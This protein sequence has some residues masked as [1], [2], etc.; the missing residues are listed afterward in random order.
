[1]RARPVRGRGL[2][3]LRLALVLSALLPVG[4]TGGGS[5]Q[6]A[7]YP[8][9]AIS[10]C[11]PR[12]RPEG[13]RMPA[14]CGR[15]PADRGWVCVDGLLWIESRDAQAYSEGKVFDGRGYVPFAK[16]L[17]PGVQAE[18]GFR[19]RTDHVA[20]QS[21]LAWGRAKE[22]A[23]EAQAHVVRLVGA[24]GDTLGLRLPADPLPV[25]VYATRAEFEG[26]LSGLVH[27][28]VGWGAFYDARTGVVHM[29]AEPAV[30]GALPW[31]ADLRHEMTHQILDL[32][33]PPEIRVRAID[34][35]WFW[36]WEGIAVWFESLGDPP[37]VDTGRD[38]I[39][40]FRVRRALNDTTPLPTLIRLSQPQFHG[41]HYDQT[42]AL[43]R[44]I[45]HPSNPQRRA[46]VL[47]LVRR[48]L[49]GPVPEADLEAALGT[50]LASLEQ[51]WL[52]AVAR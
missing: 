38:R 4:C 28:P 5:S 29:C 46:A 13:P 48:R 11:C 8:N 33:R 7:Y 21:N 47:E 30:A 9:T 32:S 2:V 50:S 52:A 31:Q 15:P 26:V 23:R 49:M 51:Q 17:P 39:V 10:D 19:M 22:F 36:L 40:R 34:P 41:R 16:A 1:M 43:M 27:D 20:L 45:L 25:T 6:G 14:F 3:T 44:Y 35:P 18:S 37:G 42:A 12:Y 24:Y